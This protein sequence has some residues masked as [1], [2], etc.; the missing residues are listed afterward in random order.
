MKFNSNFSYFAICD[1][2]NEN[3]VKKDAHEENGSV[4]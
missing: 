4:Q 2:G 1:I 3:F